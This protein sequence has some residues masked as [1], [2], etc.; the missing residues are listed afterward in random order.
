MRYGRAVNGGAGAEW[1][2]EHTVSADDAAGLIGG[3][4]ARLRGAPAEALA[5]GWDNTVF[6]VGGEWVFRFPRR[7]VAVPGVRREI[8]L[9]PELAPRLPLPVPRPEFAGRP[10]PAYPSPFWPARHAARAH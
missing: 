5:T 6:L 3:Q 9:L 4:F 8:G 1:D 7:S 2:P 10:S